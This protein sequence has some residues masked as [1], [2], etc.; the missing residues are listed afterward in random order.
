M[1]YREI[2]KRKAGYF[3]LKIHK[4]FGFKNKMRERLSVVA[5]SI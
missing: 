2:S 5:P 4:I 3:M 1:S